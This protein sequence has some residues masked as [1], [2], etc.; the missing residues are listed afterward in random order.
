MKQFLCVALCLLMVLQAGLCAAESAA[1]PPAEYAFS[2]KVVRSY[3]SETLKYTVEK[4]KIDGVVCFLSK[5]WMQDPARQI[6]KAT[7]DW[8]KN[9]KRRRW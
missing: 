6:R 7:A 8:Q 4:F 9:I 3:D 5:I 2:K 1:D